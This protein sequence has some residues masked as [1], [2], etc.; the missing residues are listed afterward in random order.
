MYFLVLLGV[1]TLLAH[2]GAARADNFPVSSFLIMWS[3]A[4]A[5]LAAGALTHRSLKEI[6]WLPGSVKWLLLGWLAP[7]L[8]AFP[9]YALVWLTGAGGV[10]NPTFLERA[11]LTANSSAQA[12]LVATSAAIT[13]TATAG[14]PPVAAVLA[15]LG[16]V[17]G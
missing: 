5:A 13:A 4:L 14:S 2:L 9:A 15:R 3:P 7:S 11:R 16:L 1:F 6:G 17:H 10:P 12:A 8:Y